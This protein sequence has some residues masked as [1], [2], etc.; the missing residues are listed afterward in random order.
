MPKRRS[1]YAHANALQ[2]HHPT[3]LDCK[4]DPPLA[5]GVMLKNVNFSKQLHIDK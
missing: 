5:D 2:L 4:A 3:D 1:V